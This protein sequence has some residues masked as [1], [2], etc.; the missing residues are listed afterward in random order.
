MNK[1]F[2]CVNKIIKPLHA[3]YEILYIYLIYAYII[4]GIETSSKTVFKM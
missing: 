2:F 1:I 4:V 3:F